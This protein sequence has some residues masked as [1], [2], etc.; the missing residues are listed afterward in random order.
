M[1]NQKISKDL[2][3]SNSKGNSKA[4][5]KERI[6]VVTG[7][8]RGIGFAI[9]K[10]L[11]KHGHFVVFGVRNPDKKN[12]VLSDL[13]TLEKKHS[14]IVELDVDSEASVASFFKSFKEQWKSLDILVN[15]AG[16]FLDGD[17]NAKIPPS[18]FAS[19]EEILLKTFNTNCLGPLR[20]IQM[21]VP[22][23]KT[24]NYGRIVNLSSGMGQLTEMSG[25]YPAYRISK[26]ALNAITRI[27]QE[28]CKDEDILINS[29]CPGWVKTDMGGAEAPRT[30]E[31]GA[32]TALWLALL[33]K[34]GPRGGFFRDQEPIPW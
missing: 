18:I 23:M 28:E 34:D 29:M 24:Q 30:P 26:T 10:G 8:N 1:K 12:E 6:A 5:S 31:K 2:S 27:A 17:R 14:A 11:L 25:F 33:P 21:A 7:A 9:A 32:E 15:N 13:T 16:V 3:T 19:T 20:M 22:M 4:N